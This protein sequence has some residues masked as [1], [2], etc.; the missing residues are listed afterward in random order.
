MC[1]RYVKTHFKVTL[2]HPKLSFLPFSNYDKLIKIMNFTQ[3][4]KVANG[5]FRENRQSFSDFLES[6]PIFLLFSVLYVT[7][8]GQVDVFS[9]LQMD[10]SMQKE[11]SL[12]RRSARVTLVV[13]F[14][15]KLFWL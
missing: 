14:L 10:Q 1:T 3:T 15:L 6:A 9:F 2:L 11:V 5:S 8:S 12:Q 7:A 13:R 4:F